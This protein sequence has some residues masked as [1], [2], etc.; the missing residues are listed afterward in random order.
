[1]THRPS[2]LRKPVFDAGLLI[3]TWMSSALF[4]AARK[5][6]KAKFIIKMRILIVFILHISALVNS[7]AQQSSDLRKQDCLNK[8]RVFAS[9]YDSAHTIIHVNKKYPDEVQY[10][11]IDTIKNSPFHKAVGDFS[12]DAEE[13]A[14]FHEQCMK[15]H[16]S[17]GI[18]I[19]TNKISIPREWVVLNKY[20][21]RYYVYDPSDHMYNLRIL[22]TD[23]FLVKLGGMYDLQM[24]HN[25]KPISKNQYV[26]DLASV[27]DNPVY[28]VKSN[29]CTIQYLD[30]EK[31]ITQWTMTFWGETFQALFIPR[32]RIGEYPVIINYSPCWKHPYEFWDWD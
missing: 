12:C 29:P 20:K 2:K 22:L 15:L 26:L 32:S 1:M 28:S 10:Y 17:S 27:E 21:G 13:I 3:L 18:K 9:K 5:E 31:E 19:N 11:F 23:S 8:Y 14:S 7:K 6:K 24:I 25:F 16:D 4:I 30:K